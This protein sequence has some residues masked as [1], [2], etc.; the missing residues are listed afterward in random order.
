MSFTR[1]SA[2]LSRMQKG[3]EKKTLLPAGCATP[4]SQPFACFR[5]ADQPR[6]STACLSSI[7]LDDLGRPLV[8]LRWPRD[9]RVRI[10]NLHLG[11]PGGPTQHKGL[12]VRGRS[13]HS[14]QAAP[15]VTPAKGP[16]RRA[17]ARICRCFSDCFSGGLPSRWACLPLAKCQLE[18][19]AFGN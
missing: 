7:W 6:H 14:T 8:C 11:I 3:R 4:S 1:L 9:L 19:S 10:R 5:T 15:S 16:P 2:C 12:S 17:L 13:A 18:H